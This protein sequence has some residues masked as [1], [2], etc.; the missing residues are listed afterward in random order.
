MSST[1]LW[2]TIVWIAIVAFLTD[3]SK[4]KKLVDNFGSQEYHYKTLPAILMFVP[5]LF[6]AATRKNFI[7]TE[8]YR[9]GFLNIQPS[10]G[11]IKDTILS[12]G[13]DKGFTVFNTLLKFVI[14]NRDILYFLIIALISIS[15]LIYVY[16]K[17]SCNYAI[18]VFLFF[19]STDYLEWL[20]NGMRQFLAVAVLF[21]CIGF[22]LKR[23]NAWMI[24]VILATSTIHASALLMLPVMYIVPGEAW[25]KLT[26][27]SFLIVLIGIYYIN[28]FTS[29]LED[30]LSSTQYNDVIQQFEYDDGVNVLR[31][32]VY[33][34]PT[35]IAFLFRRKLNASATPLSNLCTNMSVI[36]TCIYILGMF[37][38]GIYVGRIPIYFSLYNYILL[39]WEI[40]TLFEPSSKKIVY[41]FMILFYLIFYYYQVFIAWGL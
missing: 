23:K 2:F 15:A 9:S 39:P 35:I 41:G 28:D 11:Y 18:S 7:D 6:Y 1:S 38:S 27:L 14:G 12:D 20:C 17:Y 26:L 30:A 24:F 21:A 25:N 33:A 8:A 32:L 13:K 34:I 10:L 4:S 5:S 3:V 29:I 16:K 31:V 19:A 40:E 37:T 22:I 36:S